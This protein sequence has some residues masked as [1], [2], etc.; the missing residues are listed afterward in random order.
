MGIIAVVG[1]FG[2]VLKNT[3]SRSPLLEEWS[4]LGL[5]DFLEN[6]MN[7]MMV[8]FHKCCGSVGIVDISHSIVQWIKIKLKIC[9]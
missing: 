2:G 8:F 4:K 6:G 9:N 7:R 1:S 5:L 3:N